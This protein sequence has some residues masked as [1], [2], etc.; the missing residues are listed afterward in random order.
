MSEPV[1]EGVPFH[2]HLTDLKN[3]LTFVDGIKHATLENGP[4]DAEAVERLRH[5]LQGE[6]NIEDDDLIYAL[7]LFCK[8]QNQSQGAYEDVRYENR[9]R[10]P[11]D[12]MPSLYE[13]EKK[14]AEFTGVVPVLTDMCPDSCAAFTGPFEHL[15]KCPYC[16][17]ERYDEE[18]LCRSGGKEKVPKHRF[19]TLPIGPQL[20]TLWRSESGA[21]GLRYHRERTAQIFAE[22]AANGNQIPAWEAGSHQTR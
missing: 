7:R 14:I 16:G 11:K 13:L 15:E 8:L 5:P 10:N 6:V 19:S 17:M 4:L 3:T 12:V 1:E 21:Q 22:L 20:Q 2:A 9:H 18:R